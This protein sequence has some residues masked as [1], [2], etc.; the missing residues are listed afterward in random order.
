MAEIEKR[1]TR[2]Q[3][4]AWVTDQ[5]GV[6]LASRSLEKLPVPYVLILN[7]AMYS[8]ADLLRYVDGLAARASRRMGGRGR[9]VMHVV[10]T[11]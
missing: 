2:I 3:A 6:P 10:A 1:L 7:T 4:A 5:T 9:R 11:A 8:R